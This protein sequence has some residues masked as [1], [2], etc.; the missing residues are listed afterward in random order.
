MQKAL[1]KPIK[2]LKHEY[3]RVFSIVLI[4]I[5]ALLPLISIAFNIKGVDL[6][7]VFSDSNFYQSI[8]NSLLYTFIAS[9]ITIILALI[10]AYFLNNASIKGKNLLVVLLTLGMLVP[11]L[12]IG[13]GVRVMFGTK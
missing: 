5:F 3:L 2:F 12:S 6:K 13:L 11:T 4:F 10:T 9:V 8:L 1:E 7:Y